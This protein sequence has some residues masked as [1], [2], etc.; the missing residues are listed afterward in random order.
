MRVV[1]AP[2]PR[3]APVM[4]RVGIFQV[5]DESAAC[6]KLVS[7]PSEREAR[8]PSRDPGE[9]RRAQRASIWLEDSLGDPGS[10]SARL[11]PRFSR[12]GHES[13]GVVLRRRLR[14]AMTLNASTAPAKAMAK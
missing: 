11:T 5:S 8:A 7:R 9:N 4:S 1:A 10:P 2:M 14:R 13:Y 3:L 12:P 6:S